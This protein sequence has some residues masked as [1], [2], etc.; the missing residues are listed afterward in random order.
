MREDE[1]SLMGY[2]EEV[3]FDIQMFLNEKLGGGYPTLRKAMDIEDFLYRDA[4]VQV[5]SQTE[6]VWE[7]DEAIE[8]YKSSVERVKKLLHDRNDKET[9]WVKLFNI[10]DVKN[11]RQQL[12]RACHTTTKKKKSTGNSALFIPAPNTSNQVISNGKSYKAPPSK[13]PRKTKK[14]KKLEEEMKKREFMQEWEAEFN[15]DSQSAGK[16]S[17]SPI[18][19]G[20]HIK[21]KKVSPKSSRIVVSPKIEETSMPEITHL[22]HQDST[23]PMDLLASGL[24]NN[25]D[26]DEMDSDSLLLAQN[27]SYFAAPKLENASDWGRK[28]TIET[29]EESHLV[30]TSGWSTAKNERRSQVE[31]QQTKLQLQSL[32]HEERLR[33]CE[34]KYN[35]IALES[36]ESKAATEDDIRVAR[37]REREKRQRELQSQ[38][39]FMDDHDALAYYL[40]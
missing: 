12:T 14:D 34:E 21:R 11:F 33:A 39:S 2:A 15:A 37:E 27:D 13:K 22:M 17:I 32:K 4:L 29:E 9:D 19:D 8:F 30:T 38:D 25:C 28:P 23:S 40:N 3:I 7:S 31:Q 5:G 10:K 36:V 20:N 26:P 6:N 35:D 1:V 18:A 16:K 24:I